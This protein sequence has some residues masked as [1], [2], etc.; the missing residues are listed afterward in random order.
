MH[1]AGPVVVKADA[2]VAVE[3]PK[4][5]IVNVAVADPWRDMQAE[6]Q[7]TSI[8]E[9]DGTHIVGESGDDPQ[10]L[11][12][13]A[14]AGGGL[15]LKLEGADLER[16]VFSDA[17]RSRVTALDLSNNSL[18]SIGKELASGSTWLR[19]LLLS[20]NSFGACPNLSPYHALLWLDLNFVEVEYTSA[21]FAPLTVLRKL[22]MDSCGISSLL[23]AEGAPL[24]GELLSLEELS[25]QEN[26]LEEIDEGFTKG[27]AGILSVLSGRM[28]E[29]DIR[30]NPAVDSMANKRAYTDCIVGLVPSLQV[31]Q[32]E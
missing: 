13:N 4:E 15:W 22:T 30:D 32:Q 20:G 11:V 17:I 6:E 26:E 12:T 14:S 5:A 24:F 1:G 21:N 23:D 8:K 29:L 25:L 18:D 7:W 16:F 2:P 9:E 28:K 27:L 31:V 3:A 10:E 19:L